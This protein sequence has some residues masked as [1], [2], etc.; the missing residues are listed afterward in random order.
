MDIVRTLLDELEMP[1]L[2]PFCRAEAWSIYAT[3]GEG[4]T[5]IT[6]QMCKRN[7]CRLPL[8]QCVVVAADML[9]SAFADGK[10]IA[11]RLYAREQVG[12]MYGR[13]WADRNGHAL[14]CDY[15]GYSSDDDDESSF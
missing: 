14:V 2:C 13:W 9:S 10:P 7:Y 4:V 11:S 1:H 5:R 3:S 6:C 15:V 12:N 8:D